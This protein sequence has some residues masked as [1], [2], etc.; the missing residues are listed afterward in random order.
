MNLPFVDILC[1]LCSI[2]IARGMKCEYAQS[3]PGT[4]PPTSSQSNNLKGMNERG[5]PP[6]AGFYGSALQSLL[7]CRRSLVIVGSCFTVLTPTPSFLSLI[8]LVL[9]T[10]STSRFV[11]FGH[12]S[13]AI[14]ISLCCQISWTVNL[15][16]SCLCRP[17]CA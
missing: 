1:F 2:P 3:M 5:V 16:H 6:A 11:Y 8:R 15:T 12:S 9:D 7:R 14:F 4:R 13:S 17:K 10:W